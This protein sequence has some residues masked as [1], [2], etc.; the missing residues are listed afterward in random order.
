MKQKFTKIYDQYLQ[1]QRDQLS[2]GNLMVK[3]T[4]IGYW[5]VTPVIELFDLFQKTKLNKH[6]SFV[7]LGSG[8]GRAVHVASLFTKAT[9]IEFDEELHNHATTLIGKKNNVTLV[10]KNFHDHNLCVYDYIFIHPDQNISGKLEEKLHSEMKKDAKLVVFGPHF[11]PE[12]LQKQETH[13]ISGSLVS[14]FTK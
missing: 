3:D 11:H 14:I 13:D 10:N 5:G 4:G 2:R 9:G 1:F 7:D 12:E 8:D 6:K